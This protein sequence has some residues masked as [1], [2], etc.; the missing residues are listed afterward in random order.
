MAMKRHDLKVHDILKLGNGISI[1]LEE[2]SGRVARL[3]IIAPPEIAIEHVKAADV[4]DRFR[5]QQAVGI[6]QL[7]DR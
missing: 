6:R 2:K 3:S 1:K 4:L 5:E 7:R